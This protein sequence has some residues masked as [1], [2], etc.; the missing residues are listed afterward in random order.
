MTP[1]TTPR[2]ALYIE[3]GL[4][5]IENTINKNRINYNVRVANTSKNN[6]GILTKNEEKGSW[7]ERTNKIIQLYEITHEDMTGKPETTKT[8][9]KAKIRKN[10]QKNLREASVTKSKIK[11]LTDTRKDLNQLCLS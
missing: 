7:K 9:I 2:E 8:K 10:F 3:T 11:Y 1:K 5:D 6:L 4:L